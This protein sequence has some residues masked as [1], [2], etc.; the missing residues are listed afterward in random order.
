MGHSPSQDNCD[1]PY[2]SFAFFSAIREVESFL[3][4]EILTEGSVTVN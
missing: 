4:V 1:N 2:V 3:G